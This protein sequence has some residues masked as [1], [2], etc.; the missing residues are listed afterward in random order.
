MDE[1]DC[2]VGGA[3]AEVGA[4]KSKVLREGF[5]FH[6]LGRRGGR[7][8]GCVGL[9][10]AE[11]GEDGAEEEDAGVEVAGAEDIGLA[12]EDRVVCLGGTCDGIGAEVIGKRRGPDHE[13]LVEFEDFG[14]VI[15][16]GVTEEEVVLVP[17]CEGSHTPIQG[18][19][20]LHHSSH[21]LEN[22]ERFDVEG[23][24]RWPIAWLASIHVLVVNEDGQRH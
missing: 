21:D 13:G 4:G 5:V 20:V 3:E 9:R 14:E 18:H 6:I 17:R 7:R 15:N 12:V 2:V 10:E 19:R 8:V 24:D 22:F 11:A 23:D 1:V 16:V